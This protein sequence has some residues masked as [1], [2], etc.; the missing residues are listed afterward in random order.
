MTT[1]QSIEAHT[2]PPVLNAGLGTEPNLSELINPDY[3]FT[4]G[5]KKECC[6]D[7]A[8]YAREQGFTLS[9]NP[10]IPKTWPHKWWN[11]EY[12]ESNTP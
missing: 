1:G 10:F 2:T 12:I 7:E 4:W 3:N 9:D 8:R 11:D 5:D 6:K